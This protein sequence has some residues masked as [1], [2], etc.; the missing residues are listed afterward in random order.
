MHLHGDANILDVR[1]GIT[2]IDE[3]YLLQRMRLVFFYIRREMTPAS[4]K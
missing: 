4:M 2:L 1:S 3:T